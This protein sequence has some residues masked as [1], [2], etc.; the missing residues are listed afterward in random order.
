MSSYPQL[1]LA[2]LG[3]AVA[4]IGALGFARPT[5]L[6]LVQVVD[7]GADDSALIVQSDSAKT[8]QALVDQVVATAAA[9]PP[10]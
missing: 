5:A 7:L 10:A 6:A 3:V 8:A 9:S 2:W 4:L 1:W